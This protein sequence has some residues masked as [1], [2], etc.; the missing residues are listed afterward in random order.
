MAVE[1]N[2]RR[3]PGEQIVL[4]PT[5][6]EDLPD[7]LSLWNDGRVMRW[8]GFPDGLGL[9]PDSIREWFERV[10]ANPHRHHFVVSSSLLGFCGEAYYAVDP[11]RSRA[12]LDLKLRPE[13][14]GGGRART[15]L[16]ALIDLVFRKEPKVDLVWTE[17]VRENLAAR[18]L[19]W[20]CALRPE[21][22]PDDLRPGPS[23][24]CRRRSGPGA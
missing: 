23:F 12:S 22:R 14:Q 21:E 7:L 1:A 5:R 6:E 9:N 24:W 18:T 3:I 2:R 19:Y 11:G 4:H 15:A 20:S 8:V 13:A 16:A 10:E 17:P